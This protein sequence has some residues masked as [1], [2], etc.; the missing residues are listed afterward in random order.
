M[1]C[2]QINQQQQHDT[3]LQLAAA[4]VYSRGEGCCPCAAAADTIGRGAPPRRAA[5]GQGGR[6]LGVWGHPC[7]WPLPLLL[8][9]LAGRRLFRPSLALALLLPVRLL[10]GQCQCALQRLLFAD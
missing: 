2:Q 10:Q 3:S 9:L 8:L 4:V 5:A 1:L 7:C 6:N